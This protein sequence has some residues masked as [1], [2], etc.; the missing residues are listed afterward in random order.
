MEELESKR[1]VTFRDQQIRQQRR[2]NNKGNGNEGQNRKK[3]VK[4]N[5]GKKKCRIEKGLFMQGV[6][7][8]G[9]EKEQR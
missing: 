1:K 9:E 5:C 7:E 4:N 8:S 6:G 2:A 3:K